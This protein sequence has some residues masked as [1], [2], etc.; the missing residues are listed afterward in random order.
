MFKLPF[1]DFLLVGLQVILFIAYLFDF[2]VLII[3]FFQLIAVT[4]LFITGIGIL[5]LGISILQLNKNLSPFPTP[6]S[7]AQLITTGLYH[8]IRH[9]IYTGILIT[10]CGYALY[11]HSIYKI[12]ITSFL[13]I[14]F[15]IKSSYEE[16]KL[17]TTFND[18]EN[19]IKT[20]GRFFPKFQ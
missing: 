1:K 6:K 8:Y 15:I 10:C 16:E 14:L 19:Y 7:S 2:D 17:K 9:P 5:I 11:S 4:G 18:Y 20:T 3:K 12:L 13:A